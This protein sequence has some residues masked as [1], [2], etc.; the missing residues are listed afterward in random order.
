MLGGRRRRKRKA[1]KR[2]DLSA[3]KEAL[4]D[5]RAF[6]RVAKVIADDKGGPHFSID[7]GDILVVVETVPLE[8][9]VT[10][11]VTSPVG[12]GGA[13]IFAVP[14]VGSEVFVVLPDGE[15]DFMPAIIGVLTGGTAPSGLSTS[16]IVVVAPEGGEV[17]IHD[18]NSGEAKELAYK[19][20]VQTLTDAYNVH[21][22]QDMTTAPTTAPVDSAT[23][24]LVKPAATPPVT[25]FDVYSPGVGVPADDPEGTTVLKGK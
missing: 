18:G 11:L 22:H 5:N 25:P 2:P 24:V 20:D 23:V 13:G 21:I 19:S 10:C 1:V 6:V 9:E 8:E 16:T 3:I 17:L 7:D 4:R 12:G 14:P 15:I